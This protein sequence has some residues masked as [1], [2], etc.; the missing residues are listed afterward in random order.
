MNERHAFNWPRVARYV[1]W[2]EA[3]AYGLAV[4]VALPGNGVTPLLAAPP[5]WI[6]LVTTW[7]IAFRTEPQMGM[8]VLAAA[9]IQTVLAVIVLRNRPTPLV[10]AAFA[11]TYFLPAVI[12]VFMLRRLR[13]IEREGRGEG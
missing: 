7:W 12:T 11:L 9:G 10:Q 6:A 2:L 4:V 13:R 5:L 3:V 1:W 8:V